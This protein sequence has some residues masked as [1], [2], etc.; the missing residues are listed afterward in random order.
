MVITYV[1]VII[2]GII[3]KIQIVFIYG[4]G[5]GY[6]AKTMRTERKVTK[7]V[8]LHIKR[9]KCTTNGHQICMCYRWRELL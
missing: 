5:P 3:R 1:C 2:G 7:T 9:R 4:G 6:R 8:N